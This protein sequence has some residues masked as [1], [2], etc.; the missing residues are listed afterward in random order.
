MGSVIR[1]KKG[2]KDLG[3]Y[4]RWTENG[5]RRE[6]ASHQPTH[7]LAKRL[8][9]E[10]EARVARGMAGIIEPET[11]PQMTVADLCERFV[12]EF[13]N[14]QIK[15]MNRWRIKNRVELRR[16]LP[17]LAELS[18]ADLDAKQITRAR[19]AIAKKYAPGSVRNSLITLGVAF[20][21]AIKQQ[22]LDENPLTGLPLPPV[23][24]PRSEF[25][26]GEEIQ[27]LIAEAAHRT[28][29][30]RGESRRLAWESKLVAISLA[31]R[32]GL[33][34]G[35]LFGLRWRDVD[36]KNRRLTVARSYAT[37]P[38]SGKPRYLRIPMALVPLLNDWQERCPPTE[39]ELVCPVRQG[40]VW[41]MANRSG[42]DYRLPD[43]MRAAGCRVFSRPWHMLRHSFASHFMQSGGSLLALSQMLG[44]SDVKTTMIYAHLSSDFLAD[45]VD[46]LK[47]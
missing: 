1:K 35:E 42:N 32:L 28:K 6:M 36:V 22:F 9:L 25:L 11:R 4:I 24:P 17:H 43:L 23:T 20:N 37:T 40:G 44:H 26:T 13:T 5:K 47:F 2:T 41:T 29:T 10:V 31:V 38:K 46:K 45:E 16:L 33:R 21:W 30:W 8:L 18:A 7:A 15:D 12:S 39:Q 19:D 34:K 3:W 14:P 27:K